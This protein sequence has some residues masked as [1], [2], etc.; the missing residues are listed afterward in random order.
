MMRNY[1]SKSLLTLLSRCA[2][3]ALVATALFATRSANAA[4]IVYGAFPGTNVDYVGVQEE[5]TTDPGNGFFGAPT[6]AGDSMDFNPQ[7]FAANATNGSSD[8]TDSN[9]QF[10]IVAKPGKQI[11][12]IT[13]TEAGDTSLTGFGG[14]AFTS[15][16]TT[17]F[18]EIAEINGVP[19]SINVPTAGLAFSPSGGTY[20]LSVDGAP[21]PF[22][23]TSWT[24]GVL[25]DL[26]TNGV[27]KVNVSLDNT[28]NAASQAGTSAFIQKKDADGLIITVDIVPEPASAISGLLAVVLGGG[29]ARRRRA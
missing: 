14:D 22:Y 1:S 25:V 16:T 7:A 11:N 27:T 12:T 13:F 29:L 17:L 23:A 6:V 28:L 21:N 9:L 5:S 18:I 19:V 24:G 2:G 8:I 26:L 15:V 3:C 4:P 10:M 20:Q